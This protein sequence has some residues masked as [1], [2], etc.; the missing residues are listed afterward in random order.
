[1]QFTLEPQK[2]LQTPFLTLT[3]SHHQKNPGDVPIQEMYLLFPMDPTAALITY[4]TTEVQKAKCQCSFSLL[5]V[6][7]LQMLDTGC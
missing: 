2:S 7:L 3:S 4:Y 5:K 1:M 6:P